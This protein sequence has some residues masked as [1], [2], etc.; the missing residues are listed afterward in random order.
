MTNKT[1]EDEV[2]LNLIPKSEQERIRQFRK[3]FYSF[4]EAYRS[5]IESWDN[6]LE[7]IKTYR[8]SK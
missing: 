7:K 8:K 2:I 5:F 1:L 6:Y 3:T 4:I